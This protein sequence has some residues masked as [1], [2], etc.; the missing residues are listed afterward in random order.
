MLDVIHKYPCGSLKFIKLT[1]SVINE[2]QSSSSFSFLNLRRFR[3]LSLFL[4]L[5]INLVPSSYSWSPPIPPSGW[6][7]LYG[8]L[9]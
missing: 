9:W 7:V 6:F 1:Y 3:L 2:I 8:L 5:K 4:S